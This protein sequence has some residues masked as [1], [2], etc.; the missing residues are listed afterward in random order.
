[1][2]FPYRMM[3]VGH[4]RHGKD[5]AAEILRDKFGATFVSS[6]WFM[7]E[8]VV[9]PW[10]EE[11][12]PGKYASVQECYDDRA[13]HRSTWFD[14]IADS[15]KADL[16]TL[17]RAIF[18]EYDL[19]VGNRNAREFHALKN[20]GVFDISIWIDA[21]ERLEYREPRTSLTIEPWMCDFVID[22]NGTQDEL[23]RNIASFMR[24]ALKLRPAA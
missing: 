4:G 16:T 2:S 18:N 17:G 21:C 8:R 12:Y 24:G 11:K 3:V 7:A 9:F 15:N 19:Y 10:F 22:N 20:A 23:K 6:S 13:N 1:M 5:T 14:L